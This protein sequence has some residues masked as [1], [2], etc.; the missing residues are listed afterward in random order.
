MQSGPIWEVKIAII[1]HLFFYD[2]ELQ[3]AKLLADLGVNVI[4]VTTLAKHCSYIYNLD[5]YCFKIGTLNSP[6]G[7]KKFSRGVECPPLKETLAVN[8]N[9]HVPDPSCSPTC[10]SIPTVP[11]MNPGTG[12]QWGWSTDVTV[13]AY[14]PFYTSGVVDNH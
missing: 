12:G 9:Q 7:G 14:F 13:R 10:N 4:L 2:K 5:S 6:R 11:R 1:F 8:N 3:L